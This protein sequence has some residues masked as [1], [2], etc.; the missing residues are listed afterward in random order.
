LNRFIWIVALVALLVLPACGGPATTPAAAGAAPNTTPSSSGGNTIKTASG[1]QYEEII[2]GTGASPIAGQP[3]TVHYTGRLTSGAKFDSSVDRGQPFQFTIG[4]GQVIK[5]WDEGVMSMKVGG[6]RHLTIPP[7]LGYGSRGAGNVIPPNAT[8]VFDVELLGVGAQAPAVPTIA[9]KPLTPAEIGQPFCADT[10]RPAQRRTDYAAPDD[11]KLDP[12]KTYIAS[13]ETD[14][15]VIRIQLD[16]KSAPKHANSFAFLACQGYF[17]GLNFH[18]V[19]PGFVIQGGDP[20]GNGTGGPGY[21]L[22]AEFSPTLKH[23]LGVVSMARTNDP[24]SAGSQFFIMLG[25]AASLDN[26]YSI[27]G[28]TV[29]G[30]NVVTRIAV[31]DKMN[32][33]TITVR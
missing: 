21:T 12:A 18:R 26:K 27:F 16:P 15:G 9:E 32:K 28:K 24:N 2:V 33:V 1:L 4:V 20:N 14:K 22:P 7:E 23:T 29:E 13:I 25:D 8:L 17:D 3:V 19:E 31:G 5:G 6:K 30:I 10:A 11:M